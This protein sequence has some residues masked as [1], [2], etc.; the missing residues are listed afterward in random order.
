MKQER[1]TWVQCQ[2]CGHIYTVTQP[3]PINILMV[4][5][6]CPQCEWDIGLN[7]GD[8]QDDL[9]LYM[10]ANVDPRYY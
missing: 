5:S 6:E 1:E 4:N 9:Y 8:N 7:C 10:N 2:N 3:I